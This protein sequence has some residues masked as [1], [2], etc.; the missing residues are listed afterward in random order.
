[1]TDLNEILNDELF[2]NYPN[3]RVIFSTRFIN[4]AKEKDSTR[5]SQIF[6]Q[7]LDSKDYKE[8]TSI[9]AI[10]ISETV[11]SKKA[12][13]KIIKIKPQY[14]DNDIYY[15]IEKSWTLDQ[16]ESIELLKKS[17]NSVNITLSGKTLTLV[18]E[19]SSEAIEFTK[20]LNSVS[21]ILM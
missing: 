10:S 8:K 1:M 21:I 9:I 6:A 19:A 2:S 3:E 17:N 20:I 12:K 7:S 11:N 15:T 13:T 16:V 5:I 4:G 18:F 14:K